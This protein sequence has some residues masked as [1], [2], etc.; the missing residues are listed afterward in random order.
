MRNVYIIISLLAL[1]NVYHINQPLHDLG[2]QV[3]TIKHKTIASIVCTQALLTGT[4]L[5]KKD[6]ILKNFQ[7]YFLLYF[8]AVHFFCTYTYNQIKK[9][10]QLNLHF[11]HLLQTSRIMNYV[12]AAIALKNLLK[13]EAKLN[14]QPFDEINFNTV[15]MK[16]IPLSLE[17][18]KSLVFQHFL[19]NI[20]SVDNTNQN[21]NTHII[22]KIYFI[23]NANLSLEHILSLIKT[24]NPEL[25]HYLYDTY[26]NP[27]STNIDTTIAYINK[28]LQEYI[29][30][31]LTANLET[32]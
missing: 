21:V 1:C 32:L 19:K 7:D 16:N 26:T 30:N 24:S 23:D 2:K 14:F 15:I 25:Y 18:F 29:Y 22:E 10:K 4:V 9:Y 17:D 27:T 5:Y 13:T 31:N 28:H 20:N 12:L 8:I 11:T 6:S 3:N